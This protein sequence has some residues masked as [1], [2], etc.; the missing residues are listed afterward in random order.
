MME[1]RESEAHIICPECEAVITIPVKLEAGIDEDGHALIRVLA[2]PD[3]QPVWDHKLY[4]HGPS[5]E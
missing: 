4:E 1:L 5:Y 2:T 3:V